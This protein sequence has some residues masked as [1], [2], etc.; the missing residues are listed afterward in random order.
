[1]SELAEA[2]ILSKASHDRVSKMDMDGLYADLKST[3]ASNAA[4]SSTL[5]GFFSAVSDLR[6]AV[7]ADT[8]SSISFIAFSLSNAAVDSSRSKSP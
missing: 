4:M 5:S 2:A 1:M 7:L 8:V 6:M 3:L